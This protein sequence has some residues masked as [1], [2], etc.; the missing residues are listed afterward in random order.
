M[1]QQK[2]GV[3]QRGAQAKPNQTEIRTWW[4]TLKAK[5]DAGDVEAIEA[6]LRLSG[7]E[8]RDRTEVR[9]NGM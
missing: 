5:A 8:Q 3:G 1:T 9:P 2:R 4:R 6:L 7:Q